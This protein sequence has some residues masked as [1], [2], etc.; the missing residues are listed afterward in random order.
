MVARAV[1][2]RVRDDGLQVMQ[3]SLSKVETRERVERFGEFG[4]ASS[5]PAGSDALVVFIQGS[6]DHGAVVGVEHQE[7]R[8]QDLAEGDTVLYNIHGSNISLAGSAVVVQTGGGNVEL[9]ATT[10]VDG[11]LTAAGDVADAQG[12]LDAL[13]QAY[14]AHTHT[15]SQGGPT[16][17]PVPQV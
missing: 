2:Q 13:R 3:L 14:N 15:D 8:P 11:D 4:L 9:R 1:V 10:A 16:T 17:P 12:T 5:P 7:S 6:R